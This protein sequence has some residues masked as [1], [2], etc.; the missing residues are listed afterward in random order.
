MGEVT[1]SLAAETEALKQTYAALNRDDIPELVKLFDPRI[2]WIEP[3]DFPGGGTHQ[4]LAV[5]QAHLSK[6]R[7]S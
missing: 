1:P 5:V 7:E 4:G 3:A 6:G 2:E